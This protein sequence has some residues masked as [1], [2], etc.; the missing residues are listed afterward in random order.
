MTPHTLKAW[1]TKHGL[2]QAQAGAWADVSRAT[3]IRWEH[4]QDIPRPVR[5][6][7]GM[8]YNPNT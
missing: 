1:R 3:W 8:D 4:G 5:I 6:L 7:V 2:T